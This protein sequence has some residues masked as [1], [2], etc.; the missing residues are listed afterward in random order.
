MEK[1]TMDPQRTKPGDRVKFAFPNNGRAHDQ[2]HAQ[3][4]LASGAEYTIARLDVGSW[5]TDVHLEEVQGAYF[6]SVHFAS[7]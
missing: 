1:R 3:K 6:N 4:H 7:A 2:V 5:H